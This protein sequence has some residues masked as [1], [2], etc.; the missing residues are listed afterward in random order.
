MFYFRKGHEEE[1]K[2]GQERK[3]KD[4]TPFWDG[5]AK[6]KNLEKAAGENVW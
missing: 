6:T 4:T 1:N 5:G 2:K 3:E